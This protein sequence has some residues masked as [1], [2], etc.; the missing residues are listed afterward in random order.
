RNDARNHLQ[1]DGPRSRRRC[2]RW[3]DAND[4]PASLPLTIQVRAVAAPDVEQ[5]LPADVGQIV[6]GIARAM[7]ATHIVSPGG[8][9]GGIVLRKKQSDA[10][11]SYT[12]IRIEHPALAAA[13]NVKRPGKPKHGVAGRQESLAC[14]IAPQRASRHRHSCRFH[15]ADFHSESAYNLCSA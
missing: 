3:F 6:P 14:V 7:I 15:R 9:V 12:R 11:W 4:A 8:D 13:H 5:S 2:G 10:R 1:S